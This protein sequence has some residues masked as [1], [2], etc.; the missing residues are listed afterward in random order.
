M[1]V[2]Q[3]LVG[4]ASRN[5]GA[6]EFFIRDQDGGLQPFR[7]KDTVDNQ[8]IVQFIQRHDGYSGSGSD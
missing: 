3:E 7:V 2:W 1:S 5:D 8:G 6:I 4:K